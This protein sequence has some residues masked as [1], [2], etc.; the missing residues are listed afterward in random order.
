[1]N[2]TV[3]HNAEVAPEYHDKCYAKTFEEPFD[4]ALF[5]ET[6]SDLATT[7]VSLQLEALREGAKALN[8][9][10]DTGGLGEEELTPDLEVRLLHLL[11]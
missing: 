3:P 2:E 4:I 5:A 10:L 11:D 6:L 8:L 7:M 9:A 1:M